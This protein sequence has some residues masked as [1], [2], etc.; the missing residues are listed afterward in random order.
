MV[1]A[2]G[3]NYWGYGSISP[4]LI[5]RPQG[6]DPKRKVSPGRLRFWLR[7]RWDGLHPHLSIRAHLEHLSGNIKT[8][9]L[10]P[11]AQLSRGHGWGGMGASERVQK[12]LSLHPLHHLDYNSRTAGEFLALEK[13][14]LIARQTECANSVTSIRLPVSRCFRPQG[15][16][17]L[18]NKH[19]QIK[20][21][22]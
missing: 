18:T 21:Q 1:S 8:E 10:W 7:F 14:W 13:L 16:N 2:A 5:L 19:T 17:E 20:F 12:R 15:S 9:Y 4:G 6:P 22:H 3:S 11:P